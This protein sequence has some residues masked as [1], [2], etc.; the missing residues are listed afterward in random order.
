[1]GTIKHDQTHDSPAISFV[2]YSVPSVFDDRFAE[3]VL[4][5]ELGGARQKRG[6]VERYGAF[7]KE[8]EV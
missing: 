7:G 1:M 5:V 6:I 2:R 4:R 3:R 8:V